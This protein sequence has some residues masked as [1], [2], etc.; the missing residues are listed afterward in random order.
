M[1]IFDYL[2]NCVVCNEAHIAHSDS[3]AFFNFERTYRISCKCGK[4]V[5]GTN[6]DVIVNE[7]NKI[8][9]LDREEYFNG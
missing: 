6:V 3:M 2:N 1:N 8:A 9:N 4:R 5:I 7:W